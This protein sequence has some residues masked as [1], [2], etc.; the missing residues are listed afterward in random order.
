MPPA[1][2]HKELTAA[3]K[4]LLRRWVSDGAIY[5]SHWS[6][7][8]PSRP[9]PPAV[10][11]QSWI[12]NPIDRFVLAGLES[13]GLQPAPEADRPALVRRASL[14]LTGLPPSPEVVQVFVEDPSADAYERLIDRLLDSPHW[15]EHR[16]R[17]WLDYARYA[18]THGIH[19]DNYRE[20]WAYRDWVIQAFN[21]NMPFDQFTI[22]NLAGDLL[23]DRTLDQ[24]IGSGFHRCNMTTNEGGIIDEEYRVLYSRDRTETTAQVWLGLTANC[25]V[26]HDHKF[27][28]LS[29]REFYE[30]SAFFNNSTQGVRDGNVKDTPPIVMVPLVEDRTRWQALEEEVP[31]ARRQVE[32]RKREARADF[33]QWLARARPDVFAAG[34]PTSGL[35]LHVPLDEGDGQSLHVDVDGKARELPLAE[36][37]AWQ[38][39]HISPHAVQITSGGICE[40]AD[41]GD[42]EKDQ[43]FSYAAWIRLPANDGHGA[44]AARMDNANDYRGWDFWVEARRVGT[45][46]VH[47]WSEDALKVVSSSQVPAGQ[48]THVA[49]TYDGSQ[50]AAGVRVYFNGVAQTTGVQADSLQ[51]TIRTGVPLKIGQRNSSE[52][53]A[54][55]ELEDLRIYARSLAPHEVQ[56]LA[57]SARYAAIVAKPADGRTAEEK[58][59]L[60]T[61]W[62][63]AIDS[64]YRSLTAELNRLEREQSDIRA[65]GTIAHVTQE[66]NEPATAYVLYRGEYDQ[67]RDEVRPDTPDALPPFPAGLPRNRLGFARWLLL[68]EH[69]LTARVA[70]N[71]FWQEIFGTGIVKTSGDFGISG[72]LPSHPQ[73]LDWLAVDFRESGWDVKRLFKQILL[74]ATYRQSAIVTQEKLDKDPDNRLLSRGPRFR[75]DA[76]MVRDYALAAS[77]LLVPKIGGPSVKP[78]QPPGVWEAIAM[79]VSNT[80]SYQPDTGENVYRR[81]LYTFWKRM[82]P[83]AAMEV[84]NAPSREICVVR[85]ERTNTPLQA[86]L[87][88]NDEQFI[89]AARHLAQ[90]TL[91][92]TGRDRYE[93]CLQAIAIRLLA[94]PWSQEEMVVVRRSLDDLLA[95]YRNHRDDADRLLSVG[96]SKPD[97]SI[98]PEQLA[99]WTM[100]TNELMNLDEVLNK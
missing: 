12:R 39:G 24:L 40:L 65:R 34:L 33:E 86:L 3:Q 27:D 78:Y 61:W 26:C 71:R 19:F 97:P 80:R 84:M 48:W 53:I 73:L 5:E 93:D 28:P 69:P 35:H 13:A 46:I 1:D 18:D 85:R 64:S 62:L 91:L 70:V 87:T 37:A 58:D 2:I 57:Q 94:R 75:M 42:F 49:V 8:P 55:L 63:G 23:P 38:Q 16:G 95:Y 10:T 56:S 14:D 83:P 66:R 68:P 21:R 76:E 77:G 72:G 79:N 44:I 20:M 9:D 30:M 90:Q 45:H 6:L 29:Q 11:D 47:R 32:S 51:N 81:S 54:G 4:D 43:S 99:A 89:E 60:Y 82:A 92:E 67:R 41:A 31:A 7:I 50:K 25:A 100:L 22:E 52:P 17:F 59:E 74:S 15:G 88:L 98:A 96:Q 36:S